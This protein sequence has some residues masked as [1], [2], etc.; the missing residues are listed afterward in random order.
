MGVA[1]EEPSLTTMISMFFNFYAIAES[2]ARGSNCASLCTGIMIETY[3]LLSPSS[4]ATKESITVR[5]GTYHE[6]FL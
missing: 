3:T 4:S 5:Y 2:R 6:R 1:S